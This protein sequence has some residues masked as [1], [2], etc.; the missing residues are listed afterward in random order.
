MSVKLSPTLATYFAA[1]NQHDVTGMLAVFS[2]AAVVKDEGQ[3]HRGLGAIRDWMTET[4]AKYDFKVEPTAV[5]E[6]NT[7]TVVTGRVSGTFPGS[8]V[9]LR[10]TFTLHE[11]RIARLEIG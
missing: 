2:D 3:E 1:T 11:E 8:P 6:A 10:Y 5:A 4:I 9:S 7:A